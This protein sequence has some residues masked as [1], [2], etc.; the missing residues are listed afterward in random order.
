MFFL[1]S[2][3]A[4]IY[5]ILAKSTRFNTIYPIMLVWRSL[6]LELWRRADKSAS[7]IQKDDDSL[8]TTVPIISVKF[9]NKKQNSDYLHTNFELTTEPLTTKSA[10]CSAIASALMQPVDPPISVAT[11]SQASQNPISSPRAATASFPFGMH[12][13]RLLGH[14]DTVCLRA[15]DLVCLRL[16]LRC[17]PSDYKLHSLSTI[18]SSPLPSHSPSSFLHGRLESSTFSHPDPAPEASEE[19]SEA[20]S[21]R[22]DENVQF[23]WREV[24]EAANGQAG[25]LPEPPHLSTSTQSYIV[26]TDFR[27]PTL[28]QITE[29]GRRYSEY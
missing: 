22:Q 15:E 12:I 29:T 1:E 26:A 9:T 8:L 19:I 13:P 6:L 25:H 4:S 2:I 28:G 23:K 10:D 16:F 7:T 21:V 24:S 18:Y 3:F 27:L 17:R 5:L 20:C 11:S 14:L